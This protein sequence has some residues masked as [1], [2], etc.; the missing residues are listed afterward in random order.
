MED[1]TSLIATLLEAKESEVLNSVKIMEESRKNAETVLKS[2]LSNSE[3]TK[4][5]KIIFK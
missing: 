3:L 5:Y 2:L 4:D 1:T